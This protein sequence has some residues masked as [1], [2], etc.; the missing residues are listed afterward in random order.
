MTA[1]KQAVISE[2]IRWYNKNIYY[3]KTAEGGISGVKGDVISLAGG[4]WGV[5]RPTDKAV[6]QA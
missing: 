3:N 6:K 5:Q 1:L 2:S 4:E